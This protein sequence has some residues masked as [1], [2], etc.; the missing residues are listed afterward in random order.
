MLATLQDV[1][2]ANPVSNGTST[3]S[4][5]TTNTT[6]RQK[7]TTQRQRE[8]SRQNTRGKK[9]RGAANGRGLTRHRDQGSG[10]VED[11]W[12]HPFSRSDDHSTNR[13]EERQ[14]SSQERPR[15][16][17]ETARRS[18]SSG[19]Q[20][21]HSTPYRKLTTDTSSS[22][23]GEQA[24]Q[25]TP[26]EDVSHGARGDSVTMVDKAGGGGGGVAMGE[27]E[28]GCGEA[29]DPLDAL[30]GEE[31]MMDV[32]EGGWEGGGGGGWGGGGF[33]AQ[34]SSTGHS[35]PQHPP[36]GKPTSLCVSGGTLLITESTYLW[37]GQLPFV[38]C[39]YT[40]KGGE[41]WVRFHVVPYHYSSGLYSW[42]EDAWLSSA[43]HI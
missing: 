19:P 39:V 24:S 13:M 10:S 28:G 36:S 17:V 37:C 38:A 31:N 3:S 34:P 32:G 8:P 4:H 11:E 21:Y 35:Q 33:S 14:S 5:T 40:R 15:A 29:D 26:S 16:S 25:R 1:D 30:F 23:T 20:V 41:R 27:E 6:V 2:P 12:T 7:N 18:T 42:Q 43:G 22:S 9:K